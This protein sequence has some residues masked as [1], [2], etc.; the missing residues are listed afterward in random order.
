MLNNGLRAIREH[1]DN[2]KFLHFNFPSISLENLGFVCYI[3]GSS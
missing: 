1:C 2:L 3:V